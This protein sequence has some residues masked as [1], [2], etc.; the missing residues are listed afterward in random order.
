MIP[1]NLAYEYVS[2]IPWDKSPVFLSSDDY[3]DYM[4]AFRNVVG[5][6]PVS[7]SKASF[8]DNIWDFNSYIEDKNGRAQKILFSAAPSEIRD[9]CKF[10]IL[11]SIMGK[12]KIST[13]N[14]RYRYFISVTNN[15]LLTTGKKSIIS[16]NTE[17]FINEI[18][19]RN[20]SPSTVHNLYESIYQVMSFLTNNCQM[21]LNIDFKQI[22]E[23][24]IRAKN[25]TKKNMDKTKLANIP[26]EYFHKILSTSLAVMRDKNELYRYRST[27]CIIVMLSQLGLRLGD[28][29]ALTT[30]QMYS[31][32]LKKSG[33]TANYI[34]YKEQKPSKPHAPMLEFDIYSNPLCTEA[35]ATLK[36][37]RTQRTCSPGVK[38][39]YL[40]DSRLNKK[41]VFPVSTD[42]FKQ[43]YKIFLYK[44]MKEETL[45]CWDGISPIKYNYATKN[46]QRFHVVLYLPDT[47]QFRVHVATDLYN[48]GVSMTYIQ[49]YMGHLSEYMLGYYIRPKDT[50]QE[51]IEYSEQ[52]IKKIA[53]NDLT[54]LGND[55]IGED[56][57]AIIK[58][59]MLEN[60]FSVYTDFKII[61]KNL[62]DKIVIR[63]KTGGVCIKTSLMPCSRDVRTNEMLCA[64]NLCPNL[65]HFYYM[66]DVSYVDFKTLQATYLAATDSG[67]S[68]AAQKELN[69]LKEVI[70]RRLDPEIVELEKEIARKGQD[71]ILMQYPSLIDVIQNINFIKEEMK[72]WLAKN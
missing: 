51:N 55:Q 64:Y 12:K 66:L 35:Y 15:I 60:N 53:F 43:E 70:R 29:M 7:G 9:Y 58:H 6:L 71:D 72:L 49:K 33:N 18:E 44:F 40:T 46:S 19:R 56:I 48:K 69:K 26:E 5:P 21:A 3:N 28:L 14:L 67:H 1:S 42:M 41:E 20:A 68:K 13:A 11:H 63:G 52:I 45:K 57:K 37:I 39:L 4:S 22:K 10:Y 38:Y 65:F 36:H 47:R 16:I 24:G 54:P 8:E 23:L 59:F 61:A 17:D 31:I 30:E 50:Y 34:H 27:A 25:I 62:G 2:N 32:K